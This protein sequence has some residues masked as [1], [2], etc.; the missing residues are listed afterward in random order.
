MISPARTGAARALP[1]RFVSL[2]H[3]PLTFRVL[4]ILLLAG[5]IF[6]SDRATRLDSFTFDEAYHIMAGASYVETGSFRINPEHPPL[7]KLWVGAVVLQNGFKTSPLKPLNDKNAERKFAEQDVYLNNN[8]DAVQR[9]ARLA[10]F[11]LNGLLLLGL[12]LLVR[13][14]LGGAVALGTLAYLLLDPTVA[15]H[16]PV[17]MTDLPVALSSALAVL[18]AVAAFRSWRPGD[19]LLATACLGLALASKHSAVITAV[20]VVLLGVGMAVFQPGAPAV[21]MKRLAL[22][23]LVGVGAVVVL[24]GFYGF[25]YR[26]SV[27]EGEFFNRPLNTKIE[28]IRSPVMKTVLHALADGHLLPASYL[29]GLA[30]TIRAGVEGRAASIYAFGRLYYSRAPFYYTP[31]IWAVKLPIGLLLLTLAG[32]ALLLTGRLPRSAAVPLAGLGLLA[33]LFWL[34]LATGSTYG[35]V[36][37]ALA[38][39]PLLAVLGA[40]AVVYVV[41]GRSR[42]KQAGVAVMGT[43]ALVSA[44]PVVRPWEYFNELAGGPEGSYRYFS[45][46]GV[47]LQQ[48]SGE[49]IRYYRT[50]IEPTGEIPFIWYG[51]ARAEREKYRMHWVGEDPARDSIRYASDRVTGTFFLPSGGLAPSLYGTGEKAFLKAKPVAR[52]G[53]LLVYKG[54]FRLPDVRANWL[55]GQAYKALFI[56]ARPDTAKAIRLLAESVALNPKVFFMDWELGNLYALKGERQKAVHAFELAQRYVP[57]DELKPLLT[58][59][60][61]QLKTQDPRRVPPLRNPGL[62]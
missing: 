27:Q 18:A 1:S 60:I 56:D 32:L 48:R 29:W 44:L 19:L 22:V 40:M 20:G 31:G 23:G 7:T 37:H 47:D 28:D 2:R 50:H 49:L 34:A 10:M 59:H 21:R 17:V 61:Q 3:H 54:T 51:M 24:W 9:Q 43:A 42:A 53:N 52:M 38:V 8:P 58:G 33:G 15:A 30:D 39:L 11:T 41:N 13:R 26:D 45:D 5:G 12:T 25:R 4:T 6:R 55:S 16:L 57:T 46:E 14:L 36:R 62:E 35:G